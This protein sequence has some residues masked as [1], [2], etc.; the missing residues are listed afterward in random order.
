M[1]EG[2]RR[3]TQ[4]AAKAKTKRIVSRLRPG[5]VLIVKTRTKGDVKTVMPE[6]AVA[7]VQKE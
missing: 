5:E 4:K 6:D 3:G 7:Y 2:A 1:G